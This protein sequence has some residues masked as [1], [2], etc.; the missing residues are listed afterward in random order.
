MLFD[1]ETLRRP[2]S[3]GRL[4]NLEFRRL[5]AKPGAFYGALGLPSEKLTAGM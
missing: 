3:W 2:R 5:P 4:A 1:W